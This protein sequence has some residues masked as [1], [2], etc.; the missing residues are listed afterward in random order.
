MATWE[1]IKVDQGLFKGKGRVA[2]EETK[3]VKELQVGEAI[4]FRGENKEMV[5]LQKRII[6]YASRCKAVDGAI[7]KTAVRGET[8]FVYREK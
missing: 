5:A 1:K 8:L 7:Y 6:T 2:R 4:C 3:A